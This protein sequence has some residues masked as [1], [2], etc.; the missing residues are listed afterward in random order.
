MNISKHWEENIVHPRGLFLTFCMSSL[1]G[2]IIAVS[3]WDLSVL[4]M[5][6]SMLIILLVIPTWRILSMLGIIG[7]LIGFGYGHTAYNANIEIVRVMEQDLHLFEGKKHIIGTIDERMFSK[8]RST[9]Y[10][11]I[12]DTIDTISTEDLPRG[13]GKLTLFVE[14]PANL[15][16]VP[17]DVIWFTGTVKKNIHFPLIGYERYAFVSWWYGSIFVPMFERYHREASWWLTQIR[18]YCANEFRT[19][20]PRDISW[21]LLGMVI[22]M[23]QYLEND[24]KDAFM[25]SGITH[26]L[27]VSGSNIAFLILFLMFFLKYTPVKRWGRISLIG[28]AIIFYGFLVGWEVSVVRATLMGILSYFIAEY[29]RRASSIAIL[30]WVGF[31]LTLYS[32]L[33]PL[34]DAGFWLSFWAT[35]GIFIFREPLRNLWEKTRF[36]PSW[37]PFF[38]LS[39]GATLGSLP[40]LIYHFG[41]IS[42]GSILINILIAWV[43][44]WILFTSVLYIPISFLSQSIAYYFWYLIYFP[45]QYIIVLTTF[46]RLSYSITVPDELRAPIALWM[47]GVYTFLLL[48]KDIFSRM[49]V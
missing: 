41:V 44:G 23:D 13:K 20:F 5:F 18:T 19:G 34:Y 48:E 21:V 42:L 26:I 31:I 14:I 7:I 29:G 47:L 32:P 38:A 35:A 30:V 24:V 9:S 49:K 6:C 1:I 33:A 4:V 11:L 3:G 27:V 15:R 25:K 22:G 28:G 43:L 16:I 36:P 39:I 10:R 40:I 17:W 45:T 8:E 37:L 12:I 46:F 2:D